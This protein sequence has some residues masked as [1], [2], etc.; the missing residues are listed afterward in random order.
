MLLA[1]LEGTKREASR[2]LASLLLA[3]GQQASSSVNETNLAVGPPPPASNGTL[4]GGEQVGISAVSEGV[5]GAQSGGVNG[6]AAVDV[7]FNQCDIS[8]TAL[9][10]IV[11]T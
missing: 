1:S 2:A 10:I 5:P 3:G 11:M 6:G 4:P 8:I 7:S 9:L